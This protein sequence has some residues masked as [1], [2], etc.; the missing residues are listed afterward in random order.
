MTSARPMSL[1][2]VTDRRKRR[3][4]IIIVLALLVALFA[5]RGVVHHIA[6]DATSAAANTSHQQGADDRIGLDIAG[7]VTAALLLAV[8]LAASRIGGSTPRIWT[9][10]TRRLRRAPGPLSRDRSVPEAQTRAEL[11]CFLT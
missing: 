5:L 2:A 9:V 4:T 7:T 6:D 11:Q 10:V 3:W 1:R 8:L